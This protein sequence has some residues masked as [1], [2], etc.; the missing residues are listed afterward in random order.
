MHETDT[1][2]NTGNSIGTLPA[3]VPKRGSEESFTDNVL[4]V[5]SMWNLWV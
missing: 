1:V 3:T 5:G 2:E 4:L